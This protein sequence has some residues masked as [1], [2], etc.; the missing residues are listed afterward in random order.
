MT[1][2]KFHT[3]DPKILGANVQHLVAWVTW[4][5]RFVYPCFKQRSDYLE[6]RYVKG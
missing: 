6:S 3:E 1:R 5:P 4:F 2:I